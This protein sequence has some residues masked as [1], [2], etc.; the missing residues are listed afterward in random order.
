MV[1]ELS[2]DAIRSVIVPLPVSSEQYEKVELIDRTANEA[3]K[4]KSHAVEMTANCINAVETRF[5]IEMS[6]WDQGRRIKD[7]S[8]QFPTE[9]E[10]AIA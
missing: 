3:M 4:I 7:V 8:V 2:L 1:D 6:D 10:T 5:D 9:S